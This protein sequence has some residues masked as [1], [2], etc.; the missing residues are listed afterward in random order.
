[1]IALSLYFRERDRLWLESW[2]QIVTVHVHAGHAA[3]AAGDARI[4]FRR[5][6]EYLDEQ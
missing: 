4:A 5:A 6:A 1:M 2:G 3:Q